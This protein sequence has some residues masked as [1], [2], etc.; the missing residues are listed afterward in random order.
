MNVTKSCALAGIFLWMETASAI[1]QLPISS[2]IFEPVNRAMFGFNT[3]FSNYVVVPTAN[4]LDIVTPSWL[5]QAGSNF[6]ENITEPEFMFT[7]LVDGHIKDSAISVAR[8]AIN[9]T[10]G[11]AGIFDVATGIGSKRRQVEISE[12]MCNAGIPPGAYIVFPFIGPTNLLSGGLMGGLLAS[13]WYLLSLIDAALAYGDAILDTTVGAASL[14]HIN[15]LP[16][17][18]QNDLYTNQK[19]EYWSE[20]QKECPSAFKAQAVVQK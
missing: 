18:A 14:R 2:D 3:V 13:E 15:D 1:T 19:N 9:S 16:E 8:L 7:N 17:S 5:K 20:L 11:I 6:Y 12:S 10:I 4:L